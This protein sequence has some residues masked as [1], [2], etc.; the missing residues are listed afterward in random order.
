MVG[1]WWLLLMAMPLMGQQTP[2]LQLYVPFT[3]TLSW[4]DLLNANAEKLD[5]L[6]AGYGNGWKWW[7][8]TT[9]GDVY[10][11][12]NGLP[13][14]LAAGTDGFLFIAD[15]TQPCGFKWAT[16]PGGPP[17]GSA[18]AALLGT[19]PNPSGLTYFRNITDYGIFPT[20]TT[21]PSCT[22]QTTAINSAIAGLPAGVGLNFNCPVGSTGD[23]FMTGQIVFKGQH[24]YMGQNS[25]GGSGSAPS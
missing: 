8:L 2:N 18:G 7:P 6:G 9:K 14:R 12:C 16:N 11:F 23:Y 15:S 4:G 19:Y 3:G 13:G 1:K 21:A 17:S 25:H 22:D 10:G 24:T 5:G 20:C